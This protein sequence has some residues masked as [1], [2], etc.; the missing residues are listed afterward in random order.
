MVLLK[1]QHFS[2]FFKIF[3]NIDINK[4]NRYDDTPLMITT[5]MNNSDMVRRMLNVVDIDIDIANDEGVTP[6]MHATRWGY[7][8][9]VDLLKE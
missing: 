9:I 5:T 6:L 8:T 3:E 2:L 1:H 4:A 7:S